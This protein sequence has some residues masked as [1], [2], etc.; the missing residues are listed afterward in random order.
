MRRHRTRIEL[1]RQAKAR[2][3][4]AAKYEL[5][6]KYWSLK[7]DFE[8]E[9]TSPHDADNGPHERNSVGGQPHSVRRDP[10]RNRQVCD[11][12]KTRKKPYVIPIP[13]GHPERN[14]FTMI[15]AKGGSFVRENDHRFWTRSTLAYKK[16]LIYD[17][18]FGLIMIN[19]D[20]TFGDLWCT[21]FIRKF[22]NI[23]VNVPRNP[24][25]TRF[26]CS[27]TPLLGLISIPESVTYTMNNRFENFNIRLV[28]VIIRFVR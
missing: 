1:H 22:D 26:N 18:F 2:I 27:L 20:E 25:S 5:W 9:T 23:F 10:N 15:I 17:I 11:R 6:S 21:E 28:G 12:K 19:L 3:R 13:H 7:I 24:I 14:Q 8:I 16:H 4:A